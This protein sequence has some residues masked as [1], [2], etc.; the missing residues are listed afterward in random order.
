MPGS[1]RSQGGEGLTLLPGRSDAIVFQEESDVRVYDSSAPHKTGSFLAAVTCSAFF[2]M[3]PCDAGDGLRV[4]KG[5]ADVV[6]PDGDQQRRREHMRAKRIRQCEFQRV[7]DF[8]KMT[9]FL[10]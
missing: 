7:Q 2:R 5:I 10:E 3:F 6:V 1:R 8:V 4:L 9:F